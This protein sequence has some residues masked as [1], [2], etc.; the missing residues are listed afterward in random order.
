MCT[1][2]FVGLARA[3]AQGAGHPQIDLI[4]IEHPLGSIPE[5]ALTDRIEQ[6]TTQLLRLLDE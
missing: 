6:A 5:A 3:V 4:V 2:P 1:E